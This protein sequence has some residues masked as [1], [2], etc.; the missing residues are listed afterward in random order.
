[1]AKNALELYFGYRSEDDKD[2]YG[3]KRA[4]LAGDLMEDLFRNAFSYLVKDIK[5]QLNNQIL[6]KNKK[7]SL[8]ALI[9]SDIITERIRHAMATGTWVGER[10]G[11]SQLLDRT[12]YLATNSQL[13]RIVSPLSRSQPHF[14]ARELHGTHWG[15]VCP[16]ET[17]EGQNCGLVKNFALFAK[18]TRHEDDSKIIE[19]LKSFGITEF[20]L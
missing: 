20:K 8:K 12:S 16:S 4:K 19:F 6:K 10:T 13:R 14:E 2:H 11:V 18:I 17:P 3:F 9:R 5:K 7:F 1:M 15:K